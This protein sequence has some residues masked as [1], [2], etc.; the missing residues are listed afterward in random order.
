MPLSPPSLSEKALVADVSRQALVSV[1]VP[2]YNHWHLVPGLLE[3]LEAQA[4]GPSGF[5]LLLVDNG[6]DSIPETLFLPTWARLLCCATPGSYAAR[7]EAIRHA[8]GE[9]LVFTDA[10]CLPHVQWL[11]RGLQCW[12]ASGNRLLIVA[13]GISVEPEDWQRMT[14]SEIYDVALGLPQSRYVRRGYAITANLFVP[15][16]VFDKAGMFDPT[17][18]S[19]GDAEFCRRALLHG[20]QLEYCGS[21]TVSHPARRNWLELKTKKRRVKGGQIAAG[22][23]ARRLYFLLRTL[24]PPVD[25]WWRII[26]APRLSVKQRLLACLLQGRLWGVE[27]AEVF[28][29]LCGASPIRN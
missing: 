14:A 28:R 12:R 10:D 8:R 23:V 26:R 21:A 15:R 17:R 7:N 2:V 4:F 22:N 11:E 16:A 9:V 5:E 3:H 19:G 24:L 6:S 20:A 29:L 27:L 13:G 1:I 18:F 25:L